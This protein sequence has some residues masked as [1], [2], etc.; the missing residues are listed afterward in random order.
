MYSMS[1]STHEYLH[2]G[3]RTEVLVFTQGGL[4]SS[5]NFDLLFLTIWQIFRILL[6]AI[7]YFIH[8]VIFEIPMLK[9][10]LIE[11]L[12]WIMLWQFLL[13][14]FELCNKGYTRNN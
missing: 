9:Q 2:Q 5:G 4:I 13:L 14:V 7:K 1:N 8:G 6:G 12:L 10:I 11:E 3:G